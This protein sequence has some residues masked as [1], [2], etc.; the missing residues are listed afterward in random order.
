MT[1]NE[2][3]ER[4]TQDI[5]REARVNLCPVDIGAVA[6]ANGIE[7][8]FD[9]LEKEVSGILLAKSGV[10]TIVVNS[11]HSLIR[12]RFT[13]A[14]ILGRFQSPTLGSD[15]LIVFNRINH[16]TRASSVIDW[17][18]MTNTDELDHVV[19]LQFA[20]AILLPE[21]DVQART[22]NEYNWDENDIASLASLYEVSELTM[23]QRLLCLN[24]I[25][26]RS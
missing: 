14:Y 22:F 15:V 19:G 2:S 24:I 25:K 5:L 1:K 7:L 6:R 8:R 20:S 10:R 11:T 12:R 17:R 3:I 23:V 16:F 4:S 13:I 21:P 26:P 9:D 18:S